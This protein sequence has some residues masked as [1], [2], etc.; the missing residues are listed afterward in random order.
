[1]NRQQIRKILLFWMFISLPVTLIYVSPVILVKGASEGIITGSMI[2]ITLTFIASFFVG[3]VWCGWFCPMGAEQELCAEIQKSPVSGGKLNCIKYGVWLLWILIIGFVIYNAGGLYAA[4]VFYDTDS[5]IS[6]TEPGAFMVYFILL[7]VL[8]LFAVIAGKR[9]FC[10]Y[11]CPI[12]VNF[13]IAR[14]IRNLIRWPALH[15]DADKSL[16]IQCNKCSKTCPMGLDVKGMVNEGKM[17]NPDCILCA[18]CADI[19][20]RDAITFRFL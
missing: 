14:K 9:G 17:E 6:V 4:D 15:L 12:C 10:H 7:G 18:S 8:F 16:C 2:L 13:I 3:R 11:V 19:C 20:P 5:G 1:M